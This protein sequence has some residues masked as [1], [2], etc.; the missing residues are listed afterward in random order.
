MGLIRAAKDAITSSL[1]DQ[2]KD[3]LRCANMGNDLLMKKVT[4]DSG[5]ISNGSI[6]IV[7]PGQCAVIVDNGR[8][9]DATAEEGTFQYDTSSTPS[10]FAGQF[11]EGFLEMWKR[12]TFGGQSSQKQAVYFFNLK[13]IIDNKFGTSTPVPFQD[14]SH[15]LKNEIL[16]SLMPLAVKVRCFGKYT[17]EISDPAAFMQQ[18]AG[19]ADEYHT[20]QITEQIRSEVMGVLQNLF[21]ELGNADHKVPVL[22][23]PSQTDEIREMM[24]E[25]V[26][27]E[28]VRERGLRIR[29]FVIESVTLDEESEKA[30]KDYEFSASSAM[31][32]GRMTDA[33]AN[34]VENAASN[35]NGAPAG[36]IG[37]G[38][39]NMATGGNVTNSVNN[40][41]TQAQ[42]GT[43]ANPTAYDP[44][45]KTPAA[46][47]EPTPAA[48]AA[49]VTPAPEPA[50][51]APEPTA[52]TVK[53]PKCGTE[54]PASAKFCQE[55]GE[56]LA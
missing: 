28:K 32:R 38:I 24:D 43:V 16:G 8:V 46:P 17:F 23:L 4:T 22:E 26:Y 51:P 27:D 18:I 12:F 41:F 7:D 29:S 50:A 39:A 11:K 55:C 13:E 49:V 34:A 36:F 56:K 30:I 33:Y 54:N 45:A 10:F 20:N 9:V 25:K 1:H 37:L 5:V 19:T 15:A 6:I 3:A 21:N 53:C 42:N 14:W 44:Y 48:T 31:Q 52:P 35:A 40:M 47:A 2:W